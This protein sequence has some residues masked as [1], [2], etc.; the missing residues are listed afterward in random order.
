MSE[1]GDDDHQQ[2]TVLLRGN[3]A[4]TATSY[5]YQRGETHLSVRAGRTLDIAPNTLP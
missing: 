5:R 1:Q 4:P 3:I 2:G